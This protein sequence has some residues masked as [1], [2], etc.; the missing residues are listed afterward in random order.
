MTEQTQKPDVESTGTDLNEVLRLQA[1]AL[2][3]MSERMN[4]RPAA[5][6]SNLPPLREHT[7]S[8]LPVLASDAALSEDSMPVLSAF[9]EFLEL[10]RRRSRVRLM[11]IS[12]LFAV[13]FASSVAVLL[14]M[15]HERVRELKADIGAA[16]EIV[17]ASRVDANAEIKKL[18]ATA[19]QSIEAMKQDL[20]RSVSSAQVALGSNI[21]VGLKNQDAELDLLKEKLS[22]LEIE[23]AMLVGRLN[24]TAEN[25][26]LN[27]ESP[28][29]DVGVDHAVTGSESVEGVI[30]PVEATNVVNSTGRDPIL[31]YTPAY[32][33]RVRMRVPLMT[34]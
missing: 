14:W 4:S 7:T 15:G 8:N 23:N 6:P 17:E 18:S 32:N 33:R 5:L 21:T 25:E 12:L 31:I 10:E 29:E 13:L 2:A 22:A 34:P 19:Q 27:Q 24:V 30:N 11:W 3:R 1:V 9:R 16:N 26:P 20:N 28:A